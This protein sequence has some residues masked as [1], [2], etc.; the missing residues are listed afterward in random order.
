VNRLRW[1]F[2]L[3]ISVLSTVL[4]D[5][6][7]R[8]FLEFVR[9]FWDTSPSNT[10]GGIDTPSEEHL[11]FII[12]DYLIPFLSFLFGGMIGIMIIPKHKWI[13]SLLFCIVTLT[14]TFISVKGEIGSFTTYL[15]SIIGSMVPIYIS[16]KTKLDSSEYKTLT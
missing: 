3:P 2:F 5:V 8:F 9:I 6:G 14:F 13:S 7:M 12:L 1:I 11:P 16:F 10:K 4:L 15:P